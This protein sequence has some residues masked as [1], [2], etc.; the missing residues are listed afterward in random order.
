MFYTT[1]T[2]DKVKSYKINNKIFSNRN[3]EIIVDR[4]VFK[5]YF[6]EKHYDSKRKIYF[7]PIEFIESHDKLIVPNSNKKEK[8]NTFLERI[9]NMFR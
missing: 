4:P 7:V 2:T 6:D 5:A 9:I 8:N 1:T 3:I